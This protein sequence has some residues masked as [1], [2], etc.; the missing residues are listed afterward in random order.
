L[1]QEKHQVFE[2]CMLGWCYGS[3]SCEKTVMKCVYITYWTESRKDNQKPYL[4]LIFSFLF[5]KKN[6]SLTMLFIA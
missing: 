5:Y 2:N 3:T 1:A 6:M 4:F